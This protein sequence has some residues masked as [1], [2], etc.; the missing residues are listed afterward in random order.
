[1]KKV[2]ITVEIE[3]KDSTCISDLVSDLEDGLL[4]DNVK[5]CTIE[6]EENGTLQTNEFE[7]EDFEEEQKLL[8]RNKWNKKTYKVLEIEDGKV[9]LERED[10]T[11]F[12]IDEREYVK[13][14]VKSA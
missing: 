7:N 13:N 14:Y 2:K 6:Q 12:T 11:Q 1:M 8:V 10:K 3:C 4:C 5:S 9:T